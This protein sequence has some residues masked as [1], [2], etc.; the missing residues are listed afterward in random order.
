MSIPVSQDNLGAAAQL[1]P[2][3]QQDEDS[4]PSTVQTVLRQQRGGSLASSQNTIPP[5]DAFDSDLDE[6]SS[7]VGSQS[8]AEKVAPPPA[9]ASTTAAPPRTLSAEDIL[10]SWPKKTSR[11]LDFSNTSSGPG[12]PGPG[13]S[14]S[15]SDA[16]LTSEKLTQTPLGEQESF[17]LSEHQ[18]SEQSAENADQRPHDGAVGRRAGSP[19]PPPLPLSQSARRA[20]PEGC[21]A[22]PADTPILPPTVIQTPPTVEVEEEKES[23]EEQLPHDS[24]PSQ[25]SHN[26]TD[27]AATM[28]DA[29]SESS[30]ALRVAEL[31]QKESP[32][33]SSTSDTTQ[34]EWSRARGEG[35]VT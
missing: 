18:Q 31:L 8:R 32:A 3:S 5:G 23:E 20:E 26:D 10:R 17:P 29:G 11:L 24:P 21:S 27:P 13:L 28:S 25:P 33:V 2:S 15:P 9:A 4:Y 22:A 19:L 1:D 14:G 16:M 7:L 35:G 6:S 12:G 30:L 34:L